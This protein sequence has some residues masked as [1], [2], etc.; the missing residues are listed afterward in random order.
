MFSPVAQ[1][2]ENYV[3]ITVIVLFNAIFIL[4]IQRGSVRAYSIAVDCEADRVFLTSVVVALPIVASDFFPNSC[5]AKFIRSLSD[6]ET[7]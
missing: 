6:H 3:R 2:L 4:P 1:L 7:F 5:L